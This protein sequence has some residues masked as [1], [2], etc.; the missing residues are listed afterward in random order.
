[1]LLTNMQ[2]KMFKS[3]EDSN[4]VTVDPHVTI[5]VGQNESGKTAFLQALHKSKPIEQ[6]II[7]N[8]IEDYPRSKLNNYYP[9]M[10]VKSPDVVAIL[11]Y[12]LNKEEVE[13]INRAFDF[14]LLN[15]LSFT[16]SIKYDGSFVVDF[17]MPEKP[18]IT[19]IL[20]QITLSSEINEQASKA[21]TI[22]GLITSLEAL[23]LN[24]EATNF[25]S[26]LKQQFR[27]D[28]PNCSKLLQHS[29]WE[30]HLAQHIPKFLYF[31]DYYLLPGKI[32]LSLLQEHVAQNN[33]EDGD[34]TVL[35]LL[36]MAGIE[37][38]SLANSTGYEESKARLES[39][40]NSITD[41]IFE[42]WKQNQQL[43]VQFDIKEDPFDRAPFNNGKN[44]YIRI[45]NQRHRVSVPFNLRS[46]GFIWFFS[47]MVWFDSIE[48]Q[49]KAEDK[50][51]LLLDEPGLSLHALAQADFLRYIDSLAENHQI[52]YTTHS[53]FMVYSHRLHQVRTV[54]DQIKGGTKVSNN[55]LG[56]NSDTI[57]PLQA[58]L[59]YT[60][61][62]NLF[63]SKRN[64]LVEG[65]A[66]LIYLKFFSSLLSQMGRNSLREDVTIVPVGGLSNV[67]TFI[68]LLKGNELEL[69]VLHDYEN[70]PEQRL[71][72]LIRERLILEKQILNYSMFR[73]PDKTNKNTDVEDMMSVN[74]YLELFSNTYKKELNNREIREGDLQPG[75]RIVLRIG[76]DLKA[77]NT[78]I[79]PNGGYN[80][81][82]V[83]SYLASH[84]LPPEEVDEETLSRFDRLFEK[85]NRLYTY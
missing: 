44:L 16:Y 48:D 50:L 74:L 63:I 57:F 32:N 49:M 8:V 2:I 52:L 21:D 41:K 28:I 40:S 81:Y 82:Q 31:D 14:H 69:T 38:S 61:A 56:S 19:H 33:L 79:R 39:V 51:I 3:I 45:R 77:T 62:Q 6:G 71:E 53:P 4:N 11:T 15:Q 59:G 34:K 67:A 1:M 37:L 72:T 29:V 47:F 75:D 46:K 9:K 35:S 5:L 60:I 25:L 68:A 23:D 22:R 7:Y 84:P 83:A 66:D 80:H 18:Y 17:D 42:Y 12:A 73:S 30:N 78:L 64:L 58:A 70:K 27:L 54:E 13:E 55:V 26:S 43:E 20:E 10:H 36:N 24:A 76:Q 85:V 65:P